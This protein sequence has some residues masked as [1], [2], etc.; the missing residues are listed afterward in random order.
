MVTAEQLHP[1]S[2][3]SRLPQ[4]FLPES[5]LPHNEGIMNADPSASTGKVIGL[6][7]GARA[8]ALTVTYATHPVWADTFHHK[9]KQ[10]TSFLPDPYHNIGNIGIFLIPVS[11]G[12][13][14]MCLGKCAVSCSHTCSMLIWCATDILD[15]GNCALLSTSQKPSPL[16]PVCPGLLAQCFSLYANVVGR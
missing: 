13:R 15:N 8:R 14:S 4:E 16:W 9:R 11:H 7:P 2:A 12:N 1:S 6:P 3:T 5:G 10:K